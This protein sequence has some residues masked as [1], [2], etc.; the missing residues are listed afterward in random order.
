VTWAINATGGRARYCIE[1]QEIAPEGVSDPKVK[2]GE[3]FP[4]LGDRR[5]RRHL[6]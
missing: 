2:S 5:G 4:N 3:L 1:G 6:L